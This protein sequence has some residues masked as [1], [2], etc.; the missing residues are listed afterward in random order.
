M[1]YYDSLHNC[2]QHP[3]RV[4]YQKFEADKAS[5]ISTMKANE[6]LYRG[7]VDAQMRLERLKTEQTELL[8][9]MADDL[10]A[11]LLVSKLK[12]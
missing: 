8:K 11:D 6:S 4:A 1:S 12:I 9:I 2:D 5:C 3:L 10:T 7:Y